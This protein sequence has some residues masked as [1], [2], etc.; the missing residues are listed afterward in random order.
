[1]VH[2]KKKRFWRGSLIVAEFLEKTPPPARLRKNS[3]KWEK[4]Q[5]TQN[6]GN[7]MFFFWDLTSEK[8]TFFNLFFLKKQQF[9]YSDCYTRVLFYD[10]FVQFFYFFS[11][12]YGQNA[13]TQKK[14][15]FRQH[16]WEK[17]F[18]SL[19][20]FL[21]FSNMWQHIYIYSHNRI[22]SEKK[23]LPQHK[24]LYISLEFCIF[25]FFYSK[26]NVNVRIMQI[27]RG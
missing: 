20:S 4:Q 8:K 1:M 2:L 13:E 10:F 24:I 5:Q 21:Y 14:K 17:C 27:S 7:K 19:F 3:K 23:Q 18:F 11:W 9:L 22:R 26:N 15:V 25:R 16:I 6:F 12:I